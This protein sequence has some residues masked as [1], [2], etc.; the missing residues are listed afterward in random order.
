MSAMRAILMLAAMLLAGCGD[1]I[2][3]DDIAWAQEQCAARGGTEM[4]GTEILRGRAR[5]VT[6][7]CKDGTSVVG[8]RGGE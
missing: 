8:R 3:G 6:A 4:V 5:L 1:H 7:D 2:R